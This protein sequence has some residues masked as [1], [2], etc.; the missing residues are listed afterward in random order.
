VIGAGDLNAGGPA[1]KFV[2]TGGSGD[3]VVFNDLGPGG[4]FNAE[5]FT[6][7]DATDKIIITAQGTITGTPYNDI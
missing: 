2:V 4:D 3:T 6:Y 5:T 7:W 1:S